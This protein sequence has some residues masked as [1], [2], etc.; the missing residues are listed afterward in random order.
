[1]NNFNFFTSIVF[2]TALLAQSVQAAEKIEIVTEDWRPFS[3]MEDGVVKGTATEVVKAVMDHSGLEY[4]LDVYPWARALKYAT[5]KPN[6][7][8]FALGRSPERENKFKW[9]GPVTPSNNGNFYRLRTRNDIVTNTLQ[10]AKKYSIS[11]NNRSASQS[12]LQKK[13]FTD[14]EYGWHQEL[15]IKMLIRGR[16]DLLVMT[17]QAVKGHFEKLNLSTDLVEPVF[18]LLK[19]E[20]FMAFSL[21]TDDSVVEKVRRSYRELLDQK[22]IPVF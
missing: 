21:Q 8:I 9:V 7:M 18:L 6:T 3:Y 14:V 11:T 17:E 1:M 5:A 4:S 22:K 20:S 16:V 10:D 19:A 13:G 15:S 2:A 12:L